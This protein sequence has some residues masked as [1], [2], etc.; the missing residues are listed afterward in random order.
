M[1]IRIHKVWL[2]YGKA[3]IDRA[4]LRNLSGICWADPFLWTVSDEGRT[5]ECL[6][7]HRE[8]FRL[9]KQIALDAVFDDLPGRRSGDEADIESI[10]IARGNVWLCGS[11]CIVRRQVNKT[12]ADVVDSR[13]RPRRSRRLLG[14]I[15][16]DTALENGPAIAG[17]A[18]PFSGKGSLRRKLSNNPYLSPFLDLPSKEN[19]LDIEGLALAGRKLFVGLRGPLVDSIA[20]VV[21]L[22]LQ[23]TAGLKTSAPRLHFLDLGGL[24]VRDLAGSKDGILVLAGPVA[25][26]RG[27]FRLYHWRPRA[28]D[29]IQLPRLRYAWPSDGDAPEGICCYRDGV[30]VVYDLG[31]GSARISGRRVRADWLRGLWRSFR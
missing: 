24:G 19:G 8:G 9:H 3:G 21:E 25:G 26:A 14:R 28:S 18:L 17:V 12:N 2:D 6:E 16:V 15:A 4:L 13:F 1:T 11:H 20:I 22:G 29:R 30:M 5:F 23:S 27:P 10:D 31:M 7:P